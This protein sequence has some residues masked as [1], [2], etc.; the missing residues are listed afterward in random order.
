MILEE[1]RIN[2]PVPDDR[3]T[4]EIPFGTLITGGPG[5]VP[6]ILRDPIEEQELATR[7]SEAAERYAA[8]MKAAAQTSVS[9]ATAGEQAE[10]TAVLWKLL[11]TVIFVSGGVCWLGH[12]RVIRLKREPLVMYWLRRRPG[13]A[14]MIAGCVIFANA[15][16][17]VCY[18]SRLMV[19]Y[20]I[21]DDSVAGKINSL[22]RNRIG[23]LV[24]ADVGVGLAVLGLVVFFTGAWYAT[25]R[26]AGRRS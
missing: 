21:F 7:A 17:L 5:T 10:W 26:P 14:L 3:F 2:P 20:G 25:H 9:G 8:R 12:K 15:F 22:A 1:I 19:P 11:L 13:A 16:A 6:Y 24:I 18:S 4:P 23:G